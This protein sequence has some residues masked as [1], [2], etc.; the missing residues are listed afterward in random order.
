MEESLGRAN[1]VSQDLGKQAGASL[2][3]SKRALKGLDR[4][5]YDDPDSSMLAP[6]NLG[7]PNLPQCT[8]MQQQ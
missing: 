1:Q 3:S 7:M 6:P 8:V 2:C 5:V 4:K